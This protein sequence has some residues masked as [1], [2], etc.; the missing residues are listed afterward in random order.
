MRHFTLLILLLITGWAAQAQ[1]T[2]LPN[3]VHDYGTVDNWRNEP[4]LF[5]LVNTGA[6]PLAILKVN[7]SRNI[8]AEYPKTYIQP[9]D[10]GRIVLRFYTPNE[11]IF[12]ENVELFLSSDMN[13]VRLTLKGRIK[14]IGTDALTACPNDQIQGSAPN[15]YQQFSVLDAQTGK[16]IP[17]AHFFVGTQGQLVEEFKTPNNGRPVNKTYRSGMY[18]LQISAEGYNTV[19]TGIVILAGQRNFTFYLQKNIPEDQPVAVVPTPA[20]TPTPAIPEPTPPPV[21]PVTPAPVSKDT[22]VAIETNTV[23]PLSKYKPNNIVFVLDVSSSMRILGR[24][25]MLK[26]SML[27]LTEVLRRADK[28]SIIT[29]TTVPIT[30]IQGAKGDQ[31][32][33]LNHIIQSFSATG[34]T[35]GIRGLRYAYELA[36]RNFIADGNNMVIIGTDGV[37]AQVDE[38]GV[39]ITTMVEE[40][41]SKNVKLGVMAFGRDE[42]AIKSMEKIA[43]KGK[44]GFM[45]MDDPA[46][47]PQ[48]L[49]EQIQIQSARY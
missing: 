48:L 30:R 37:F 49:L 16:A 9:G 31:K 5:L 39:S 27:R 11:G 43:D 14:S 38:N 20:P 40:Y 45:R 22:A 18:V 25:D 21:T 47:A 35:N 34:A 41:L 10:T 13:P 19:D 17:G 12:N 4:S 28:V 1:F 24:L 7:G 3:A 29:F 6:K 2:V 36:E 33:T 32:D 23:L 44:G 46:K 15:F 8:L 26:A 42:A